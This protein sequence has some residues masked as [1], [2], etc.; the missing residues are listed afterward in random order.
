MILTIIS[1]ALIF[2]A[3]VVIHEL[4]HFLFARLF[5]VRILAFGIGFGP[6]IYK[7]KTASGMD[8]KINLFPLGGYVRMDGED[9]TEIDE[10]VS[11]EKRKGFYYSKTAWQRFLIALAGPAFSI[12]AGYLLLSVVALFW[13]IPQVG[14]AK[15][16]PFSPA[17]EA[18]LR[19]DDI[20]SKLNGRILFDTD[21]LSTT[22]KN[23]E[24]VNLTVTRGDNQEKITV[25]P[26]IFPHQYEM[27]IKGESLP[28]DLALKQIKI[29]LSEYSGE[30]IVMMTQ[31]GAE[32]RGVLSGYQLIKER[33]VIGI[34]YKTLSKTLKSAEAPFKNGDEILTINDK[35]I[36]KGNDL[37]TILRFMDFPVDSKIPY[38]YLSIR[39]ST[40]LEVGTMKNLN[41]VTVQVMRNG[42]KTTLEM[43][44]EVFIQSLGNSFFEAPVNNKQTMNPFL[45]IS[46]GFQWS[47]NLLRRMGM[48]IGNI[49]TGEQNISEFSGPVGIV[50]II[51]QATRAGFESLVLIFALITL[52]LGIINLIPL[53]A[54]DGGRIV[55]NLIEM[56][57]RKKINPVIEGYIH[58]AGFFFIMALAVY[59]TYFDILRFM[60]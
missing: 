35:E 29:D 39:D 10:S 19:D 7:K 56:V 48:I 20:I 33:K 58:A 32:I 57:S 18:G 59:I 24:S 44:T 2:T 26:E 13:G 42:E 25:Y 9:P 49:F 46:W 38:H 3:I 43:P 31:S 15:V 11:E 6:A 4:G 45:A 40:I 23:S 8:F 53:P 5:K 52:N 60:K 1:F 21:E 30:E 55:F 50:N 47:N 51:G 28:D 27:I 36:R 37:F 41:T 22:I 12:L 17:M 14:I 16:E 34:E 54:L